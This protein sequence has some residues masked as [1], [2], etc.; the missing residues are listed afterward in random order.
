MLLSEDSRSVINELRS[1]KYQLDISKF[2]EAWRE[3]DSEG[4]GRIKVDD[5][6]SCVRR[7][8]SAVNIPSFSPYQ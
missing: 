1:G 5:V 2:E 4:A 8:L 7:I 6:D 3:Y